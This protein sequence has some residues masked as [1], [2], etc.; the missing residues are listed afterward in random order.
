[1]I[2]KTTR[3]EVWPKKYLT[4]HTMGN[5]FDQECPQKKIK[6]KIS[7]PTIINGL[8]LSALVMWFP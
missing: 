5:F 8:S 7:A 2:K 1:M 3:G 6:W 4:G